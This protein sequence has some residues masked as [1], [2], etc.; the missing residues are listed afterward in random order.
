MENALEWDD[1]QIDDEFARVVGI[2]SLIR[3]LI[4]VDGFAEVTLKN[5]QTGEVKTLDTSCIHLIKSKLTCE[6]HRK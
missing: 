6:M 2:P 1:G 4:I 5:P 3:T